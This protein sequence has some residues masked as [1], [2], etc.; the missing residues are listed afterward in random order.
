MG[1]KCVA[2]L[3]IAMGSGM[4]LSWRSKPP[5]KGPEEVVEIVSASNVPKAD[6]VSESDPYV[7]FYVVNEAGNP[8]GQR[9]KTLVRSDTP[10]PVWHA[11]RSVGPVPADASLHLVLLDDDVQNDE[12]IGTV[13]VCL[14]D[15]PTGVEKTLEV[16]F[17]KAFRSSPK[18]EL[19][20][21]R[22][23]PGAPV[24]KTVFVIRHG[25]SKWNAAQQ[26]M[27]YVEM[28][29]D[30]DHPL[31]IEGIQ[32]ASA[33]NKKI[34]NALANIAKEPNKSVQQALNA[35]KSAKAFFCSPFTRAMETC[36]IALLKLENLEGNGLKLLST[37]REVKNTLGLDTVG[38][39]TGPDIVK[40]VFEMLKAD[41]DPEILAHLESRVREKI[42]TYDCQNPWW[43]RVKDTEDDLTKRFY[44]FSCTLRFEQSDS[45]VVV[46]HSLFFQG[47][48]RR[49]LSDE[50]KQRRGSEMEPTAHALTRRKL[51]N[52]GCL[53][54]D[55]D[56]SQDT[57]SITGAM[58]M[59]DSKLV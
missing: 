3:S 13:T 27:N 39:A 45:V 55:M 33:L 26:Q 23:I 1:K 43:T 22:R 20:I 29:G 12:K 57:P 21:M 25:E 37:A 14:A 58:L 46:G 50:F 47:M 11:V 9:C 8:I 48:L 53:K 18:C 38:V 2:V 19:T 30:F 6:I 51:S 16:T 10:S 34:H 36:L 4:S 42:H 41:V 40:R 17:A 35:F 49:Y 24:R 52:A 59:F 56:F 32:Q 31:N 15:L 54:L 28:L 5:P 7:L 44:D